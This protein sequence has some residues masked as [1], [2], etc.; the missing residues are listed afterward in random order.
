MATHL[1]Q[2]FSVLC[3]E[4]VKWVCETNT[5]ILKAVRLVSLDNNVFLLLLVLHT[6]YI[7]IYIY[8]YFVHAINFLKFHLIC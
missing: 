2:D 1:L 6:M 7:Y 8:I 5:Y 3:N 4:V